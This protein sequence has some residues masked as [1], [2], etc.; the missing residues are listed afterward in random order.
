MTV[1]DEERIIA[2]GLHSPGPLL[3]VKKRLGEIKTKQIRVIV[4]FSDAADELV[5]FFR[6]GGAS[7]EID[8]AGDDFHV[9][10]DLKNFKDVK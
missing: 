5:R 7:T 6:E 3:V 8:R 2:R 1:S 10:A 4:S 9:L